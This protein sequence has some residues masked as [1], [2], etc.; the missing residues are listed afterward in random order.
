MACGAEQRPLVDGTP[1]LVVGADGIA[2]A[3]RQPLQGMV[4]DGREASRRLHQTAERAFG[5]ERYSIQ[6]NTVPRG[7]P[8][9]GSKA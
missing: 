3:D 9:S 7:P 5:P 6:Q 2:G 1:R 4:D 8:S